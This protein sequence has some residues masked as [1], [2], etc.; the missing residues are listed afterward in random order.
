MNACLKYLACSV[1]STSGAI[2][3]TLGK[4]CMTIMSLL[5]SLRMALSILY[6]PATLLY[7]AG[8]G[9]LSLWILVT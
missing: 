5:A 7:S 6:V 4:G 3:P 9:N 2:S 1:L 8:S